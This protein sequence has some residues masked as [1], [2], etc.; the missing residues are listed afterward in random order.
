[1]HNNVVVIAFN[2][3]DYDVRRVLIDSESSVDVLFY[4]AFSK[5]FILNSWLESMNSLLVG[6]T[7]DTVLVE[8]IITLVVA[9]EQYPRKSRI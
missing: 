5:M 2:I 3:A 1:M 7:S 4:D 9:I 8:G 6:F